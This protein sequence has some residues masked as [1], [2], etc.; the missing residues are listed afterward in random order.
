M[1]NQVSIHVPEDVTKTAIVVDGRKIDGLAAVTIRITGGDPIPRVELVADAL[2]S[3][4]ALEAAEIL[5]RPPRDITEELA[6]A[7]F[8][9][10]A[11]RWEELELPARRFDDIPGDELFEIANGGELVRL[12]LRE[13]QLIAE[14]PLF[15]NRAIVVAHGRRYLSHEDP[16]KCLERFRVRIREVLDRSKDSERLDWMERELVRAAEMRTAPGAPAKKLCRVWA[17]MGELETLR[18]TVD[19]ARAPGA[20]SANKEPGGIFV[21]LGKGAEA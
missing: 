20:Q 10:V 2:G 6:R 17:I 1:T 19:A 8:V 7:V 9:A 4:F 5:V 3:T 18:A 14:D 12:Q 11:R 21:S 15:A 16:A 13:V